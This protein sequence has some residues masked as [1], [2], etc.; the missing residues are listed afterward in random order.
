MLLYVRSR[1]DDV[2][3]DFVQWRGSI[4]RVLTAL[5]VRAKY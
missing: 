3:V 1:S 5:A 2:D 4:V